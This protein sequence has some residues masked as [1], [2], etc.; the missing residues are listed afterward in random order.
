V[1]DGLGDRLGGD[2]VEDHPP[3]RDLGLQ[4]LQQVP[5]DGLALAVLVSGEQ[6]FVGILQ[7][8]LQLG[9]LLPLVGV[10]HV[11]RLEVGVH[12]HAEPRPGLAAVL[13]RYLGCLVRHVAD[14]PDAGL[15]HVALAEVPGNGPC[16]RR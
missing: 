16:L 7:G 1:R 9:D 6:Q 10:D 8:S 2:L 5:G 13:G 12:V 14:V 4:L 11:Q 15:D 3:G